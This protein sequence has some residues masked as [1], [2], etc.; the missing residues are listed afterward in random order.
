MSWTLEKEFSFEASHQLPDHDGKCSRLH[1]HSWR[2]RLVCKGDRLQESG[3][4]QGM[5]VDFSEMSEVIRPLL[6]DHLDHWHLNESLKMRAPTSEAV[7]KWIYDRIKPQLASLRAVVIEE[8]CSSRCVYE[9]EDN[10][11]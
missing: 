3:P 9:P 7:A 5:L 1:G 8:T 11:G 10:S 2:G 6:R 4:K